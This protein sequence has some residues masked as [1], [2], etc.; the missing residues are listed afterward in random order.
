MELVMPQKQQKSK[1][2]P[3]SYPI[4][5]IFLKLGL[6]HAHQRNNEMT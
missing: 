3:A 5:F 2:N 6:H 1:W 4:C